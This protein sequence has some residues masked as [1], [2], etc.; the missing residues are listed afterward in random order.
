MCAPKRSPSACARQVAVLANS[1]RGVL[2]LQNGGESNAGGGRFF[3]KTAS[4]AA[5]P[6]AIARSGRLAYL[7]F[8]RNGSI[9][10]PVMLLL[11][12]RGVRD[13]G[14]IAIGGPVMVYLYGSVL[15]QVPRD[16]L[17]RP[18]QVR[19]LPC[20]QSLGVDMH[21]LITD[22]FE[23]EAVNRLQADLERQE[24]D[25]LVR[26]GL[27]EEIKQARD[28]LAC[29]EN[30]RDP[31]P[32]L[33]INT[34]VLTQASQHSLLFQ[35]PFKYEIGPRRWHRQM[36]VL[37]QVLIGLPIKQGAKRM[38][39]SGATWVAGGGYGAARRRHQHSGFSMCLIY[40]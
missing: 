6:S 28:F 13:I 3:K 20:G 31:D 7:R 16:D 11:P 9:I 36:R 14:S 33:C 23:Q 22:T 17:P 1:A 29:L 4:L 12:G 27:P 19:E 21:R 25:G 35:Y 18:W 2:N 34:P 26:P 32:A 37:G 5:T 40:D 10:I 8:P 15:F 24:Q 39:L 38:A 30:T